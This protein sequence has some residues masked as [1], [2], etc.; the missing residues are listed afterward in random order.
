MLHFGAPFLLSPIRRAGLFSTHETGLAVTRRIGH[1][2][3]GEGR[4]AAF[5]RKQPRV[6]VSADVFGLACEQQ[7]AKSAHA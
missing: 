3:T 5:T 6:N 4:A 7:M 1:E 2:V